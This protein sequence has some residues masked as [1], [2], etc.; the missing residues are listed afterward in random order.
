M[1]VSFGTALFA[2]LL[3]FLSPCV[4]PLVP[5]YLGFLGGVNQTGERT[6][7]RVGLVLASIAFVGG[8]ISVFI[9][10]G[11]SSS[12]AGSFVARHLTLLQ[13]LAGG[14]IVVLGMHFLGLISIG[15]LNRDVRF[16]P[17][18]KGL[19]AIGAYIVGLA[20]GFGWT[21]CVG[22]VLATILM[23][24]ASTADTADGMNLLFAYGVGLGFPFIVVAAFADLFIQKFRVL[25]RFMSYIKWLLGGFLIF[26]GIAM[27]TGKLA[28]AG[29]WLF[30]NVAFFQSVG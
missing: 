3:S 1:S 26:T 9:A 24:S 2:G 22:P 11:V 30:Q 14:V 16:M 4:L 29:Y 15:F 17:S 28:D 27:M 21:P 10:L 23:I 19:N 7:S 25:A 18:P 20:F 13:M 8:F 6:K 5:G 12:L